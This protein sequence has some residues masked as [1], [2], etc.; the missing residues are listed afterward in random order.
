MLTEVLTKALLRYIVLAPVATSLSSPGMHTQSEPIQA[1]R[2]VT[3]LSAQGSPDQAYTIFTNPAEDC[4]TSMNISWASPPG[5]Q[6]EI[7]V[8]DLNRNKTYIYDYDNGEEEIVG[9]P[10][11]VYEYGDEANDGASLKS[12]RL[13]RTFDNIP[14]KLADG[15]DV[16]EQHV[17]DKHDYTL[18]DLTPNTKYR[19][20]IITVNP[21]TGRR[22][23]SDTYYFRTAGAKAWKA[24]IIGDFHHYAPL[25]S[26]LEAAMGMLDTLEDEAAG[27]D[28]VLSTGDVCAWGGSYNF[29]TELSEQPQFKDHMWAS[30]QGNHDHESKD[31]EK[32]DNFFRDSHF[33]PHNGYPGQEGVSYWFRYGDVL[34]LM[35]NTN[36]PG[37]LHPSLEWMEEVVQAHP[38]K[39]IVVVEHHQWLVGTDGSDSQLDRVRN[40]FDRIGV[41]LAISGDNHVYLRTKPIYDRQV[42]EPEEGTVYIVT[43]SSDDSRGR[44]IKPLR[45]NEDIIAKRWSEGAHT[46]GA[47]TM[48]VNPRRIQM[49]LYDRYGTPQDAFTIPAK[50]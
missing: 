29:W 5:T 17:F 41:D 13:C 12:P 6:C 39:Y 42:V 40:V 4:S 43:P 35:L 1:R 22:Q 38:S 25:P 47:M 20:R 37:G 15:K 48:D 50:R 33:F 31:K 27:Y 49:T 36:M 21:D 10:S 3:E 32:S 23:Y 24:A 30:V 45:D 28:W 8:T 16:R 9:V 26:R 19:Y 11:A 2:A 18:F 34:F 14:S 7:E 44:E 46:V